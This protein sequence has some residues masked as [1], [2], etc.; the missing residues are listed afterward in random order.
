MCSLKIGDMSD[1]IYIDKYDSLPGTTYVHCDTRDFYITCNDAEVDE[2]MSKFISAAKDHNKFNRSE[3]LGCLKSLELGSGGKG[4]WR[5]INL[6][7]GY[8]GWLKYIR[9]VKTGETIE[10]FNRK[11][12]IYIAYTTSSDEPILLSRDDLEPEN[13]ERK[14][15]NHED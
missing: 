12:P 4:E 1:W 11:E 6:K 14:Y 2:N 8:N 3:I 9:F 10:L 5:M 13:I 15:L 7:K